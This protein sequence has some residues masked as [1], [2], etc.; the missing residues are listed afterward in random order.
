MSGHA[1]LK[2]VVTECSKTQIRLTRP[3]CSHFIAA[4]MAIISQS[5]CLLCKHEQRDFKILKGAVQV[6]Y[7]D[8]PTSKSKLED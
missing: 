6:L 5:I 1:Q 2:F 8:V 7:C 4:L 3:Y